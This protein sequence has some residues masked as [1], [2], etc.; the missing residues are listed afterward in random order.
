MLS[1]ILTLMCVVYCSKYLWRVE[2]FDDHRHEQKTPKIRLLVGMQH[3]TPHH[4]GLTINHY[5]PL[6][7]VIIGDINRLHLNDFAIVKEHLVSEGSHDGRSPIVVTKLHKAELLLVGNRQ[8]YIDSIRDLKKS[9]LTVNV[10]PKNKHLHHLA[11]KLFKEAG[12]EEGSDVYL[13][14]YDD[15]SLQRLF[16]HGIDLFLILEASPNPVM[17]NLSHRT[18]IHMLNMKLGDPE[19]F[20][21]KTFTREL[22]NTEKHRKYYPHLSNFK[23]Q[24]IW[25]YT[26]P[27]VLVTHRKTDPELTKMVKEVFTDFRSILEKQSY[28]R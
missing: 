17:S 24:H 28:W 3:M 21:G 16:G 8:S 12:L 6:F 14:F 1:L 2:K 10:G 23:F 20:L 9:G 25:S 7:N 22:I 26:E 15:D 11:S 27:Y 18:R 13:S 5:H 19:N 4:V